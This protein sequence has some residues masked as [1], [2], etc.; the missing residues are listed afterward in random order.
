[1][2]SELRVTRWIVCLLLFLS[3]NVRAQEIRVTLHL[4]E[5]KVEDALREVERQTGLSCSYES[6]LLTGLP[7]V[8]IDLDRVSLAT[9]LD[10][11]LQGTWVAWTR[12]GDYIILKRRGEIA[13]TS[14]TLHSHHLQEILVEADSLRHRIGQEEAGV[15]TLSSEEIQRI[16]VIFGQS[17]VVRSLQQLPG[18]SAGAEGVAGMYVRGGN[19]DENL[20]LLDDMSLYAVNHL[21]GLF[22]PFNPDAIQHVSF[23][24]SGF[25]ARYGGRLSSVVDIKTRQ[26]RPTSYHGAISL[27]LTSGSVY[28]EGPIVKDRLTFHFGLRRSWVDVISSPTLAI[29]NWTQRRKGYDDD[30]HFHYAF[31]DLNTRIDYQVNP[32][33]RLSLVVYSGGDRFSMGEDNIFGPSKVYSTKWGNFASALKW[34]SYLSANLKLD[35]SLSYT[36]YYSDIKRSDKET[37]KSYLTNGFDYSYGVIYDELGGIIYVPIPNE[38]PAD[39]PV[40]KYTMTRNIYNRSLIQDYGLRFRFLAKLGKHNDL[41]FGTGYQFH[42]YRPICYQSS[43]HQETE[44]GTSNE[45][46]PLKESTSRGSEWLAYLED[47]I[48]IGRQFK[49]NAG[50]HLSVF[51]SGRNYWSLQPRLAMQYAFAPKWQAKWSYSR[52]SQFVHLVPSTYFSLPNDVWFPTTEE[53]RPMVSD[54]IAG[55]IYYRPNSVYRFSLEGYYKRMD[56]LLEFRNGAIQFEGFEDWQERLAE[57]SGRSYGLEFSAHRDEGKIKGWAGY[58]LSWSDR[59][60]PE[61]NGGKRYSSRFDNRHKINVVALWRIN[62]KLELNAAWMFH[63]GNRIT[64]PLEAYNLPDGNG[65]WSQQ[66]PAWTYGE[67]NNVQLPNYH[68]LDLGLNIY[69]RTKRGRLGIWNISIYNAYCRMNVFTIRVESSSDKREANAKS[70]AFLPIIPMVSYTWK[71]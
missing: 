33:N 43:T 27:G 57:G 35:A 55:G 38:K 10:R 17:D 31:H 45:F 69:H 47:E 53:I 68:R 3:F 26:E 23:Y 7:C 11:I 42:D 65:K 51:S 14:D 46:L 41:R 34:E 52:M 71:F 20:Y 16:P 24:K 28:L 1:M 61:L 30:I 5:V 32:Y 36:R 48:R 12:L 29:L 59:H 9:A 6:L 49:V 19:N 18:V 22:S 25:P 54:Q 15:E 2:S 50:L 4:H 8:S 21:G 56:N 62:R 39:K 58:T 64:L 63:S 37:E 40:P 44:K 60:F 70:M 66:M 67:R 13:I